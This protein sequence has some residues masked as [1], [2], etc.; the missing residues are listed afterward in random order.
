MPDLDLE[1]ALATARRAAEAA[2]AAS[3]VH[4]RRG[5]RVEVKPDRS[6]VTVADREAEAAILAV[7]REAFPGHAFLG[8]ETGA[9]AGSARS[10]WIVDPLD[11]TKGFTRGRGFWG[12]LVALEHDGAIVAGAMALPALGEVYWAARGLGAWLSAG[13]APPARLS[14]SRIGAWSDATL[15]LGE[16][17]VLFRPPLLERVAAL[18]TSAQTA[19]CYGDLA[20]CALVLQGKAE[21]WVEAGVQIWDLGPIPVLVEEAGGRFTDLDGK[22]TVASGSCVASNG[23]VHDHVLRALSGR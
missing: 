20:G 23:L 15:S 18:A 21:A 11:G 7:V 10:R 9:H 13:G 19:R 3:L 8:E 4:F 1:K 6:P 12:P 5:V 14:V 22:P 16:P 17:H 2:S